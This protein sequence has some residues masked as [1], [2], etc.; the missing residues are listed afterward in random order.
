M[1][2]TKREAQFWSCREDDEYLS[3][4]T[5]EEAVEAW[6]DDL[7]PGPLP[8]TV[9]V[10]GFARM[11]L[12]TTERLASEALAR[13]LEW[14]D[15]E[16]GD[17]HGATEPTPTME[18]AA[19]AFAQTFRAEYVPWACEQVERRTVRVADYYDPSPDA[20]SAPLPTDG[21]G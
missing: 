16:Y 7:H 5:I 20:L 13:L 8:E 3:H 15:E 18:A 4:E 14:M 12:P 11:E 21:E 9:T 2:E 17:P 19:F 1:S 10:Y 6:A